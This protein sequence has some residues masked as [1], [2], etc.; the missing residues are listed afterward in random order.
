MGGL[1]FAARFAGSECAKGLAGFQDVPDVSAI[2]AGSIILGF[3]LAGWV[4]YYRRRTHGDNLLKIVKKMKEG[5]DHA[6]TVP[7]F[8]KCTLC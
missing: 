2:S 4:P 3:L 5:D 6:N 7:E 1:T 8:W